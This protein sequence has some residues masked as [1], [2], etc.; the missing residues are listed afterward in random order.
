MARSAAF[1]N[2][3]SKEYVRAAKTQQKILTAIQDTKR[4]YEEEI[5]TKNKQ[6]FEKDL[7]LAKT[8][9]MLREKDEQIARL[10]NELLVEKDQLIA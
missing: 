5:R 8:I 9:D 4:M 1:Q 6:I 7:L 3:V 10:T 2:C